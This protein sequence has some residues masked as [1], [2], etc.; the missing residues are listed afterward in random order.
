MADMTQMAADL[1]RSRGLQP[2]PQNVQQVITFFASNPDQL[3]RNAMGVRN[4]GV[5]DN[6]AVLMS[7][8]DKLMAASDRPVAA[9]AA[10]VQE[11]VPTAPPEQNIPQPVRRTVAPTAP[12]ELAPTQ[13][14]QYNP[15]MN[16]GPLPPGS[17]DV[18]PAID[19][20]TINAVS[21][22]QAGMPVTTPSDGPNWILP[23][24][25]ALLG[26]SSGNGRVGLSNKD[27][28]AAMDNAANTPRGAAAAAG[29]AVRPT[30]APD[31]GAG[32]RPGAVLERPIAPPTNPNQLP[33][34]RGPREMVAGADEGLT[35]APGKA[36]TPQPP[37][38]KARQ[39]KLPPY[40]HR[41]RTQDEYDMGNAELDRYEEQIK[42]ERIA[43]I[44]AEK[45]A[46]AA[47]NVK[48]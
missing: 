2:T 43:Q 40:D 4:S 26:V 20:A 47:K 6:S 36:Q 33:A 8:L 45:L 39:A 27:M 25:T 48:K 7:Q 31:T 30:L 10:P 35:A 15:N 14:L 24:L 17:R 13:G 19:A 46:K 34:A 9:A 38:D 42:K 44:R 5:D 1:I 16:L 18:R 3:E 29:D 22:A 37:N 12:R 32:P 41:Q 21:G 23:M 11:A 28:N